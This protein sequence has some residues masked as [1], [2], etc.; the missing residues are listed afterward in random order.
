[1]TARNASLLALL[2]LMVLLSIPVGAQTGSWAPTNPMHIT[3]VQHTITLLPSG[4]VLVT[5]GNSVGGGVSDTAE[6]Y[7]PSNGEW[8]YTSSMHE[9][10]FGHVAVLLLDGRVLVA[11]GASAG[12]AASSAT[13]E[14]YDPATAQW[15]YTS[16][17]MN[18]PRSV[19]W[20]TI[21]TSGPLAGQ[22]LVAGGGSSAQGAGGYLKTAELYDPNSGTW[23]FTDNIYKEAEAFP[24]G[25]T[26]LPNGSYL[27]QGGL[28]GVHQ[29]NCPG[30]AAV[31]NP[32]TKAWK[33]TKPRAN[34]SQGGALLLPNGKVLVAG[35]CF[36]FGPYIAVN[37]AQLYD[38][39][40]NAWTET[41]RMTANRFWASFTALLSGQVLVAGGQNGGYGFGGC[42][43]S[44][45]LYDPPSGQWLPA[46]DMSTQRAAQASVL[47]PS[48]KVLVAGGIAGPSC[49]GYDVVASAEIYT[50]QP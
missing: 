50:P 11:G 7:D 6:I 42:N 9:P 15:T 21:F 25:G 31:F 17:K 12:Y 49:T 4:K 27:I 33:G 26:L 24:N 22:V 14:I 10:R 5:G 19:P 37:T 48:G 28:N 16:N 46:G 44:A 18:T 32:A 3:R 2:A 38:P 39:S 29:Y 34:S 20:A 47:L 35:G 30:T 36:G 23:T 40:L 45:E 43:S 13:A 8:T 41:A 1:M